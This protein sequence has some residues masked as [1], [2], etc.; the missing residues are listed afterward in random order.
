MSKAK[1]EVN[2][3]KANSRKARAEA[4]AEFHFQLFAKARK[5]QRAKS[6]LLSNE[7]ALKSATWDAFMSSVNTMIN[8]MREMALFGGDEESKRH[9][10]AKMAEYARIVSKDD[11]LLQ[12][13][14]SEGIE[15]L[16][17]K[18]TMEEVEPTGDKEPPG[19][20]EPV[21][22]IEPPGDEEPVEEE[23]EPLG[24]EDEEEKGTK[25]VGAVTINNI[26]AVPIA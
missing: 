21:G 23:D 20:K 17:A 8:T 11:A 13:R 24:E 6:G 12:H 25:A 1:T 3:E 2:R 22:D 7:S 4:L 10:L 5:Y 9:K 14:A 16:L 18:Y 26:T 15:M 19:E